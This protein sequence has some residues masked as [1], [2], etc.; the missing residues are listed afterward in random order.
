MLDK[1]K[2]EENAL[3][4]SLHSDIGNKQWRFI[5]F[6]KFYFD[7]LKFKNCIC[8]SIYFWYESKILIKTNCT[9]YI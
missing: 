4:K 8:V 3:R 5:A 6:L 7:N 2:D 9:L 1:N